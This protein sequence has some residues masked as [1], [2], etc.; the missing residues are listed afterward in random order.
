[1]ESG[2]LN[3]SYF[4]G[5]VALVVYGVHVSGVNFQKLLGSYLE[6]LIRRVSR[7]LWGGMI[8]GLGITSLLHSGGI[9]ALMLTGLMWDGLLNLTAALPIM[10]GASIGSTVAIQL[11]SLRIGGYALLLLSVGTVMHLS[12]SKL[13]WNRLGEALIGLSFLFLGMELILLGAGGLVETSLIGGVLNFIVNNPFWGIYAGGF[14]TLLLQSSTAAAVTLIALSLSAALPLSTALLMISGII[15]GKG[16]RVVYVTLR[17]SEASGALAIINLFFSLFGFVLFV[18][19]FDQFHML[20]TLT[21]DEPARQI[22]NAYTL[23]TFINALILLPLTPLLARGWRR[24]FGG[25]NHLERSADFTLDRRLICTPSVSITEANRAT[26][27]MSKSARKMLDDTFAI[28]S[29]DEPQASRK[30]VC[31]QEKAVDHLTAKIAAYVL[32]IASQNLNR[33]DTIR[34]YSLIGAVSGIEH[35]CDHIMDIADLC[36]ESR[37]QGLRFS[38]SARREL[39]GVHGKLRLMQNLTTKALEED[40]GRLAQEIIEHENKVD[41]IIK[42][43]MARHLR[44][45][46]EG[47]CD[48]AA[49]EYYVKILNN[50]ERVGDH[51][52]NLAYSIADRFSRYERKKHQ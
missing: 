14:L 3:F 31:E 38:D 29:A 23:F 11:A 21:A 7:S 34:L 32:Q 47:Q 19:F 46:T 51:Y 2:L 41:E 8:L 1:M 25:G 45:V 10:L 28:L 12:G 9:V 24:I 18:L 36:A 33:R 15:L 49:A 43:V 20:V 37:R 40:N 13:Y 4:L 26:V 42:K 5:G 16:L 39:W 6:M 48:A 44:R 30:L 35:L 17:H 27:S 50:L 52:D 22:A